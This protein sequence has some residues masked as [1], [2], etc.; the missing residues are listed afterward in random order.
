M[1]RMKSTKWAINSKLK[2]SSKEGLAQAVLAS[3]PYLRNQKNMDIKR[4]LFKIKTI[5]IKLKPVKTKKT[6]YKGL[7]KI[8][9][10][11]TR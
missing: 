4:N 10:F 1:K 3:S 9:G 11:K 7:F 6:R 8:F 2:E 5:Q